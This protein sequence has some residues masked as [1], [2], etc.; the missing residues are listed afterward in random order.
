MR[1]FKIVNYSPF[2]LP[3]TSPYKSS[4]FSPSALQNGEG[5]S[6]GG[7]GLASKTPEARIS[8]VTD[9]HLPISALQAENILKKENSALV[10]GSGFSVYYFLK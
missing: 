8:L 7:G 1:T 6:E 4:I 10:W 9:S 5:W 2:L 3:E